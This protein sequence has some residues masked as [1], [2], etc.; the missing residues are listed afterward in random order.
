[1]YQIHAQH[2]HTAYTTEQSLLTYWSQLI[3]LGPIP[4]ASWTEVLNHGLFQ[5]VVAYH[6]LGGCYLYREFLGG[7]SGMHLPH[8]LPYDG[9]YPIDWT[10]PKPRGGSQDSRHRDINHRFPSESPPHN[11]NYQPFVLIMHSP[12]HQREQWAFLHP[13][14][15]SLSMLRL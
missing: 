12:L 1:M 10:D 8:Q 14:S 7:Y 13:D 3:H 5:V 15:A 2:L 4:R 11:Q 9:N 6:G